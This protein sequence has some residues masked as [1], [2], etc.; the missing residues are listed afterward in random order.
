MRKLQIAME[1]ML[2]FLFVTA[3]FLVLF[4]IISSRGSLLFNQEAY[5]QTQQLAQ[6]I[7]HS[8]NTAYNGG[9]GY[10]SNTILE[11]GFGLN[12]YNIT[13]LKNGEIIHLYVGYRAV[14]IAAVGSAP[15]CAN[16]RSS[17]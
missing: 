8:I 12:N 2:V 15:F 10:V 4:A 9:N 11:S 16:L 1:F 3:I 6:Q 13:I 7:A 5:S 17:A 14:E